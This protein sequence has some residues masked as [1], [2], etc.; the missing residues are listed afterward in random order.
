[1]VQAWHIY[2]Y[3]MAF[4][5]VLDHFHTLFQFSTRSKCILPHQGRNS[6]QPLT[7]IY[8][9]GMHMMAEIISEDGSNVKRIDSTIDGQLPICRS[10]D[11]PRLIKL[12]A[13]SIFKLL[14][15]RTTHSAN[16]TR[17]GVGGLHISRCTYC[18]FGHYIYHLGSN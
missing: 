16:S 14:W 12:K 8:A 5:T 10:W 3:I 15:P 4:I 13:F 18:H 1:M 11:E 6:I 17:T 9:M 7:L 2:V